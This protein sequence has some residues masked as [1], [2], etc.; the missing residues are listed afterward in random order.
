MSQSKSD[1]NDSF[2]SKEAISRT[3]NRGIADTFITIESSIKR[4]LGRFLYRPEDV[5]EVAQE[6]FLRAYDACKG[7]D[8]QS[9]KAYLYRVAKNMAL[10]ELTRKSASM[11]DYLEDAVNCGE[12]ILEQKGTLEE[13]LM[14]QQKVARYCD[15]IAALPPRCRKVFLLRKVQAKTH[16]EIAEQ[17]HISVSMVEKHIANGV[18]KFDAYMAENPSPLQDGDQAN[19]NHTAPTHKES[20]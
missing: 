17:L 10:K 3:G 7:R 8:I 19:P 15:A 4:F 1:N 11:T 13:E 18:A 9:P 2:A 20:V 14:A 5:D 12:E 6:T 16:R